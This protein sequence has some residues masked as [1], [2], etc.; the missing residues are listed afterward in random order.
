MAA[1]LNM[2]AILA[3]LR[4]AK[5]VKRFMKSFPPSLIYI[6]AGHARPRKFRDVNNFLSFYSVTL[7]LGT[8]KELAIKSNRFKL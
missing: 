3:R 7:K 1:L 2:V 8:K 4:E 5:N 6:H